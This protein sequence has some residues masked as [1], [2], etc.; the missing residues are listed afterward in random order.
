V[1][2]TKV[3]V[4]TASTIRMVRFIMFSSQLIQRRRK[5][6]PSRFLA[7]ASAS[8]GIRRVV[9]DDVGEEAMSNRSPSR[10]VTRSCGDY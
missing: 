8:D 6:K 2:F 4:S 10:I 7:R 9:G 5:R 3:T 1:T